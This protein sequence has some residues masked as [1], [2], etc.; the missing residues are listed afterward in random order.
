VNIFKQLD[1]ISNILA[2]EVAEFEVRIAKT[3][4]KEEAS[5]DQRFLLA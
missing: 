2:T 1:G 5:F 4:L 3:L